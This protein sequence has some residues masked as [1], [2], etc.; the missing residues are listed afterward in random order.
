MGFNTFA[1]FYQSITGQANFSPHSFWI[2]T[3]V[4]TGMVGLTVYLAYFGW[5]LANALAFRRS[6]DPDAAHIGDGLVA[7]MLGTAAANFFYL[8][9]QF[10]YFFVVAALAVSG[11]MLFGPAL[12]RRSSAPPEAARLATPRPIH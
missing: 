10:S 6:S 5:L 1:V 8:T 3:L 11:A 7:A 9:M 4:E 2:A 12:A